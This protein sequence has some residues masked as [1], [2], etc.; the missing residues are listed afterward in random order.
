[1]KFWELTEVGFN[2]DWSDSDIIIEV[3]KLLFFQCMQIISRYTESYN[4]IIMNMSED[5]N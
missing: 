4:N 1:M 5:R 3:E 2:E